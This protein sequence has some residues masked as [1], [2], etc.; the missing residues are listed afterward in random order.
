MVTDPNS[1]AINA[2][3]RGVISSQQARKRNMTLGLSLFAVYTALYSAF[4]I[5]NAF[6]PD[7]ME[8][9]PWGGLNLAL[10]SGFGLICM[11]IVLA[12]IYGA[13]SR[14]GNDGITGTGSDGV[15]R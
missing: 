12:F 5:A 7:A 14:T 6:Y 9:R 2:P 11:A 1:S 4:V 3:R 10:I 13:F 8:A 15:Q